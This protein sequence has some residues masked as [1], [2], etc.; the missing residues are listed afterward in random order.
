[1]LEKPEDI[2]EGV[3]AQKGIIAKEGRVLLVKGL[4]ADKWDLPGGRLHKGEEPLEGLKREIK[5]EVGCDSVVKNAV[6]S[7]Q[8]YH[9]TVAKWAFFIAY[10]VL[11][12]SEDIVIPE[13]EIAEYAWFLPEEVTA[14]NTWEN[15]AQAVH[16]YF[17]NL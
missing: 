13:D 9:E 16:R 2:F 1:V 12:T 14:E 10:E 8:M 7:S 6:H 11:L 17:A 4:G 3:I 15:A 5:E